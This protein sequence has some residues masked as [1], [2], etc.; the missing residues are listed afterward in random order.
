MMED[1]G[2]MTKHGRQKILFESLFLLL[3]LPVIALCQDFSVDIDHLDYQDN[4][5]RVIAYDFSSGQLENF[6]TLPIPATAVTLPDPSETGG[7]LYLKAGF[8]LQQVNL[9]NGVYRMALPQA[10]DRL[11]AIPVAAITVDGSTADWAGVG[12]YIDDLTSESVWSA[13]ASADMDDVKLAYS[14]DRSK[15]YILYR[16]RGLADQ[17][18]RY[19]LFLDKNLNGEVDEPDD[20]QIDVEYRNG[21]WEVVSQGW[22]SEDGDD[23]YPIDENGVVAV[24]GQYIEACVDT[25]AFGLPA[26]MNVYGRTESNSIAFTRDTF[27][28]RYLELDG[29][30]IIEGVCNASAPN[31]WSY[32]VRLGNVQNANIFNHAYA[33]ELGVNAYNDEK[34][35]PEL[36]IIWFNGEYGGETFNNALILEMQLE[37]DLDGPSH[38]SWEASIENGQAVIIPNARPETD[39]VD[40]KMEITNSGQ[41]LTGYYRI[42]SDGGW[43]QVATHTLPGGVGPITGY[44]DV[45]PNLEI[46]TVIVGKH[47]PLAPAIPMLLLE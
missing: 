41:T 36:G 12:V 5:D 43:Q 34:L 31:Q 11:R 19:R 2:S 37:N 38:Y 27:S 28:A 39:I 8:D 9:A 18:V 15:L 10:T 22:N 17:A 3:L 7:T 45:Y 44:C 14:P 40:L 30:S 24:A 47:R 13:T 42:N 20:F 23:W 32:A 29:F 35:E 21:A 33:L 25:S 16:L 46:S 4:A 6:N 26:N 1:G